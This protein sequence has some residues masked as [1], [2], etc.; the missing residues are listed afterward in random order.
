MS[1]VYCRYWYQ[2]QTIMGSRSGVAC[3]MIWLTFCITRE[4]GSKTRLA[5]SPQSWHEHAVL[6]S[7]FFCCFWIIV[8]FLFLLYSSKRVYLPTLQHDHCCYSER[9]PQENKTRTGKESIAIINGQTKENQKYQACLAENKSKDT[10]TY[11]KYVTLLRNQSITNLNWRLK[12][13]VQ[14]DSAAEEKRK[15]AV[16]FCFNGWVGSYLCWLCEGI[17]RD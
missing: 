4:K 3:Q 17:Y 2:L 6:M 16:L 8:I 13:F 5:A 12:Q 14:E 11:R 10:F 1:C 15:Q 9:K 7:F